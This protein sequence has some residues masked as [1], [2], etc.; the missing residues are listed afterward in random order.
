M[1]K[2]KYPY[3]LQVLITLVALMATLSSC[4]SDELVQDEERGLIIM[5]LDGIKTRAAGDPLFAG[6]EEIT[7]V[8]IFVFINE[9]LEVNRLFT[10]GE[11]SFNNPFVLDVVTGPKDVYVVA[12][13]NA[14][15]TSVLNG[16][17]TKAAL[18]SV[19]IPGGITTPL[20]LPL[21]M[22]GKALNVQV[23]NPK[24]GT[25]EV[26]VLLTR[27]AAKINLEL[28]K[29]TPNGITIKKVSLKSNAGKSTLWESSTP[30]TGQSYYNYTVTPNPYSYELSDDPTQKLVLPPVYVYENLATA[31]DNEGNTNA[32]LLEVEAIYDDGTVPGGIPTLYTVYLNE[33]TIQPSP[34][35]GE[36]YNSE[37]SDDPQYF[38]KLRRGYEYKLTGT[39]VDLGAFT[40]LNT[41]VK[42]LP[43][44]VHQYKVPLE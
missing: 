41:K 23:V 28:L 33:N 2:I 15:L 12:N 31:P 35:A 17:T 13:E 25:N 11:T 21:M 37:S 26:T 19:P 32:T 14:E 39:I 18:K 20:S 38:Y 5:S 6:D 22:T 3:C 40:L 30:V 4:L 44:T 9:T 16:I 10:A 27:A 29:N 8:R 1:K 36:P 34:V 43:W 42:V 24:P 7:K